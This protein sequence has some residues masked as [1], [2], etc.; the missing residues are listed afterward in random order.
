ML[1]KPWLGCLGLLLTILSFSVRADSG[2]NGMAVYSELGNELFIA[3]LYSE[4]TG[5]NAQELIN[6]S[7]PKRIELKFLSAA[8]MTERQ[9]SRLWR[10]SIAINNDQNILIAQ[11]DNM[12]YFE[13]LVRDRLEAND[14]LVID[15]VPAR[16]VAISLNSVELGH[17]ED[18]AFFGLLL[19]S[20]IGLVPSSTKFRDDLLS[21][22]LVDAALVNRFNH[23]HPRNTR[24][25]VAKQWKLASTVTEDKVLDEAPV[26]APVN[27]PEPVAAPKLAEVVA[28]SVPVAKTSEPV[29][30]EPVNSKP[31]SPIA[32]GDSKSSS[33]NEA[34]INTANDQTVSRAQELLAKQFYMADVFKKIY[35]N[36]SYPKRAQELQQ[37][38]TVRLAVVI[39]ALGKIK[40]IVPIEESQFSLLNKAALAAVE[41]AAPFSP[42]PEGFNLTELELSVPI[43]FSLA[44]I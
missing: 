31:A 32:A 36:V 10:E 1:V 5:T 6:G 28:V 42:L 24:V 12:I 23:M 21:V 29:K 43:T 20:W 33:A 11:A 44:G 25:D 3:A 18:D 19:R 26:A 27:K 13:G 15:F 30:T 14:H 9:F 34:V 41:K 8:G 39:D 38:G 37:A 16:G 35:S 22:T 17:I 2:L 40:T 7:Y 4:Q